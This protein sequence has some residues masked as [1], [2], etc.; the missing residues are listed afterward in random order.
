MYGSA[1]KFITSI[2]AASLLAASPCLG[3][4]RGYVVNGESWMK[5]APQERVAYSQGLND[6]AN[7]PY[8][9]D[10]LETAVMKMARTRCLAEMK[11]APNMLSD[12]VTN[13]YS[14]R[15][16]WMKEPPLFIYVVRMAEICRPIINEE[17]FRMGLPQL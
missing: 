1:G 5:M 10:N 7:F 6:V 2:L 15:K 13:G 4:A 17:R 11:I 9:D 14:Q 3:Q 12:I 8:V 16:E